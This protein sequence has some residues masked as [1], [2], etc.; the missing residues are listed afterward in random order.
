MLLTIAKGSSSRLLEGDAGEDDSSFFDNALATLD[1]FFFA[2]RCDRPDED[3]SNIRDLSDWMDSLDPNTNL[4][5]IT[6]PGTHNS[7]AY[8]LTT[9]FNENDPQYN[10]IQEATLGIDLPNKLIAPFIQFINVLKTTS[11]VKVAVRIPVDAGA[12]WYKKR[13]LTG[14]R[15]R[16][17]WPAGSD[18]FRI[19]SADGIWSKCGPTAFPYVVLTSW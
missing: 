2:D 8:D 9:K 7:A 18:L 14:W 1:D 17:Q 13:L 5:D 16:Q 11:L 10:Y 4:S 12:P 15:R 3:T 19:K 6:L